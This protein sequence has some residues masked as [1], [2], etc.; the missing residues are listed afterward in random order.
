MKLKFEAHGVIVEKDDPNFKGLTSAHS[1]VAQRYARENMSCCFSQMFTK[2]KL[3]KNDSYTVR[4][5]TN[6]RFISLK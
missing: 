2:A 6:C 1:L 3:S 5:I 4:L